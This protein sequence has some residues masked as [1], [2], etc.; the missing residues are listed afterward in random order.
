MLASLE[1]V[2][3]PFLS[4]DLESTTPG[5]KQDW[6]AG[7]TVH[8]HAFTRTCQCLPTTEAQGVSAGFDLHFSCRTKCLLLMVGHLSSLLIPTAASNSPASLKE[9]AGCFIL[10]KLF[11]PASNKHGFI[12]VAMSFVQVFLHIAHDN[13][14]RRCCVISSLVLHLAALDTHGKVD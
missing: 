5:D 14:R 13:K 8:I 7:Y 2:V 10:W 12:A 6:I 3:V 1:G 11:C 4:P 9:D